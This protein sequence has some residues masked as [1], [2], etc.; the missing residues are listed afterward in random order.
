MSTLLNPDV[1]EVVEGNVSA[2]AG[3]V[4]EGSA[5]LRNMKL[6]PSTASSWRLRF[7]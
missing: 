6:S 1:I 5:S 3:V 4:V 7:V 2:V